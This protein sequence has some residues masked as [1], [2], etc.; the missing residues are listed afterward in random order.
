MSESHRPPNA[1]ERRQALR[2]LMSSGAVD[3]ALASQLAREDP[4]LGTLVVSALLRLK[5][6]VTVPQA[7]Y[8]LAMSGLSTK[9]RLSEVNAEQAAAI[10]SA[11]AEANDES[12]LTEH[13]PFWDEPEP[14]VVKSD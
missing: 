10:A 11:A 6:D 1:E 9:T 7:R 4:A 3:L 2:D 12:D 5:G 14:E 8:A 13:F